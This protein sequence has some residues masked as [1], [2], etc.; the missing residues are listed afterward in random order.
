MNGRVSMHTGSLQRDSLQLQKAAPEQLN[1]LP[2]QVARRSPLAAMVNSDL[3]GSLE[4]LKE[5]D[6][7]G[8][9]GTGGRKYLRTWLER[10]ELVP[11]LPGPKKYLDLLVFS[12]LRNL[13]PNWKRTFRSS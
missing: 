12:S 6:D 9:Q 5:S 1:L 3:E 4:A 2:V 11:G 7:V 13:L 8:F 10:S